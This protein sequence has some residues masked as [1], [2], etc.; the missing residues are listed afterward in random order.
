MELAAA[1]AKG[2]VN[3]AWA[4]L[5]PIIKMIDKGARLYIIGAAHYYGY[6]CVGRPG[7]RSISDLKRLKTVRIA[8]PGYGAPA[9]ILALMIMEKYHINGSIVF[10][11][12]PA[13]LDAVFSGAVD[14]ACLP[15][16]YLSIAEY[17]GLKVLVAAQDVWKGIPGNYPGSYLFVKESLIRRN[18]KLVC[19]LARINAEAIK[20]AL[21]HPREAAKIDAAELGIP[22]TVAERSLLRLKLTWKLDPADMQ[23]LVDY[24][25]T[26]HLIK[27]DFNI[28]NYILD[29][30][31]VCKGWEG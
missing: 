31:S 1:F 17:K 30:K 20:Y 24:M 7:I 26:H 11:R 16:H 18:P 12:P 10:V 27:H 2:D 13:I 5:A 9:H 4:C 15:E 3:V 21:S 8:V 23:R 19:V 29:L 22:V 28:S 6:G 25:Y 14:V